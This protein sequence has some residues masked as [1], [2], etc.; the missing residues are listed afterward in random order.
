MDRLDAINSPPSHSP[1]VVLPSSPNDACVASVDDVR[2]VNAAQRQ[3]QTMRE[4]LIQAR[5]GWQP[6]N[7]AELVAY[8]DLFRFLVRREIKI[9][10]A[11]SMIGVGW[12]ILQPLCTMVIF[13]IVF[14]RL[15]RISSDGLPYSLFS[16][17]GLMPWIYF[18]SGVTD[19]VNSL[20]ANGQMLSKV[21]FPRIFLPLSAVTAR[22]ADFIIA[23]VL[24]AGLMLWHGV[25]PSWS[26]L[27]LPWTIAI[28]MLTT[29]GV[30]CWLA[31]FAIQYRDV[32]HAMTFI[33]QILM[34]AAPVVYPASLVPD[35]FQILYGLNPMVGVIAGFR[36]ALFGAQPMPW[37]FLIEGSLSA[38]LIAISGVLYFVRKQRSFADVA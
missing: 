10:Y 1:V 33:I 14:G 21:Y 4:T 6:V 27:A 23:G 2:S 15:A 18:S 28:M 35:R 5:P 17:A 20:I 30:A 24:L 38:M 3:E 12:A 25:V 36:S 16:F 9:R 13:L 7:F 32:K 8:R 11:Q 34:Y 22:L 37:I 31:T 26:I 19:G 29:A